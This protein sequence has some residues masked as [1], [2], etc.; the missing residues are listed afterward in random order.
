MDLLLRGIPPRPEVRVVLDGEIEVVEEEEF[1]EREAPG[2]IDFT[3]R[4]LHGKEQSTGVTMG[5]SA[6]FHLW[7]EIQILLDSAGCYS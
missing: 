3:T 5:W 1:H 2:I 4:S 7:M 6:I